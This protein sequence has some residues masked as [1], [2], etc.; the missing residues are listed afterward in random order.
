MGRVIKKKKADPQAPSLAGLVVDYFRSYETAIVHFKEADAFL[1]RIVKA[2]ASTIVL[3]DGRVAT[4]IDRFGDRNK[5][6]RPHG[7]HRYE[8][9]VP[10]V[11]ASPVTIAAHEAKPESVD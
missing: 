11:T 9:K 7:L 10:K 8:I 3:E 1:D 6:F 5:V 2:G 4:V